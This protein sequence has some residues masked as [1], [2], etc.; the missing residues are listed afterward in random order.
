MPDLARRL[1][2]A[3]GDEPA[4]LVIRGAK[5]FSV[6][7]REWLDGDLA[8]ADG[9]VAGI[10]DYE[11]DEVLELSGRYLVPGFIDA[12]MHLESSKLLVD[13]FARLVLPLGTTAVVADPHEIANVLGTDGVHW[14]AD[15]CHDLALDVFFMASS[16]VP[17]SHFESPRRPLLPGDL[18]GLLN[19]RRVIGLAEMM[20][21]P[22][23]VSGS[24]DE[25][26]KLALPGA[27]HVDGHAPSVLGKA[28]N[29]YAAAGIRSDH[30]V[31]TLEE[32]RERLRAGMWVLIREASGARNLHALLPLV[33]E[34][35]PHRL[36]FCTDDREPEHI[37]EEG[38]VNSM[39][40]EAVAAG[41]SPE[42]ALVMASFNPAQW[43]GL[44]ELGAL[45]PGYQADVLVLPDLE[46]F[47]PELVLKSGRPVGEIPRLEVPEWVRHTVRIRP[48]A[49]ND[50]A[51]PW[52]GDGGARVI[53]IVPDQIVTE[54]LV[55]E[56]RVDGAK[57]VSD[58]ERDLLK[59]AVV[60][61]H[62]GTG[63]IGLGFV[64]GFGLKSGA[65]ASTV[66]H[67]A[68][69]VVVVGVKDDDMLRAV[70]RLADTGG[71]VVVVDGGI[72]KAELKLPIAGLLSDASL[73]EVIAASQGCVA[74]AR[75]L[76]CELP[77]PFQTMAFLALSVIPSL[78]ITD[79]GLVDVDR[80]ELVPLRA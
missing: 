52:E 50:F 1:A 12:H 69:N 30:E 47:V 80:F 63:R 75:S 71:G 25:L 18:E 26:A 62:L 45:A 2:V 60:E 24:D 48:L 64:R 3:R 23:V 5:V 39:V 10:G 46:R 9:F 15:L 56:P 4:D 38:H 77:S 51:V 59:I 35:G 40:R 41:V 7:T 28:L 55:D 32:G 42:D 78:K 6:F 66:A 61:R 37:A 36:A 16:C 22:G 17:A 65:L 57:A 73:D 74:A 33:H 27:T 8:V 43:H 54:S 76:G 49:T 44:H 31:S 72:V 20:N 21:F 14:L 11:G 53:G 79:R 67:D 58:P 68:H 13:E 34:F 19:R 29:A 70:R